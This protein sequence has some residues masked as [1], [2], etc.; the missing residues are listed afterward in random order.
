MLNFLSFETAPDSLSLY[1][2]GVGKQLAGGG[3][4]SAVAGG[5]GGDR[6]Y[7]THRDRA[8]GEV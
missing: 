3:G 6:Q 7:S 8:A 1:V 4:W 5:G 2:L